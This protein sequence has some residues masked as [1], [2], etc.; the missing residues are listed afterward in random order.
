MDQSKTRARSAG[1]Y[2]RVEPAISLRTRKC[3]LKV[4]SCAASFSAAICRR[5]SRTSKKKTKIIK[6][7]DPAPLRFREMATGLLFWADRRSEKLLLRR[8]CGR[9]ALAAGAS[10]AAAAAR[11]LAVLS[12]TQLARV[13]NHIDFGDVDRLFTGAGAAAAYR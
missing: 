10:G 2:C 13:G 12:T 7:E 1:R 4:V 6:R 3:F 11:A 8:R 5:A 9:A